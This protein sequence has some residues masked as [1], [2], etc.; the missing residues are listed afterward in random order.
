[1]LLITEEPRHKDLQK[2]LNKADINRSVSVRD[3]KQ[4]SDRPVSFH[5]LYDCFKDAHSGDDSIQHILYVPA[6]TLPGTSWVQHLKADVVVTGAMAQWSKLDDGFFHETLLNDSVEISSSSV[7]RPGCILLPATLFSEENTK[8]VHQSAN[9]HVYELWLQLTAFIKKCGF[10]TIFES[11]MNAVKPLPNP[12]KVCGRIGFAFPILAHHKLYSDQSPS[13]LDE[14]F[15][16]A[17][18]EELYQEFKQAQE[19]NRRC[20]LE[21][22]QAKQKGPHN[23]PDELKSPLRQLN[24][25][26]QNEPS[27]EKISVC[28]TSFPA[29]FESLQK[30]LEQIT[31]H[32]DAIYLHLNNADSIPDFI[33]DNQK[34]TA[35]FGEDFNAT[36]KTRHLGEIDQGYIFILDDDNNIPEDYFQKSV[37]AL[38]KYGNKAAITYHG[39]ILR[40]DSSW[41]YDK[42]TLYGYTKP[43]EEDALVTLPGS[44]FL[45]YHSSLISLTFKDFMPYTMVDLLFAIRF[46]ESNIP[47]ICIARKS[48][49][50]SQIEV[51]D[52][53]LWQQF[54]SKQTIHSVVSSTKN[55]CFEEYGNTLNT[56]NVK[57]ENYRENYAS[58]YEDQKKPLGWDNLTG[59]VSV[60]TSRQ[61]LE[62][63]YVLM[64]QSYENRIMKGK[65]LSS[66]HTDIKNKYDLLN[67]NYHKIQTS[68]EIQIGEEVGNIIYKKSVKQFCLSVKNILSAISK[69]Q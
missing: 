2:S 56:L 66:D 22:E 52:E 61:K 68:L 40:P 44:G 64:S 63:F 29:R 36:G 25:L 1:V 67:T 35:T 49:W 50:L 12:Y 14:G 34:I 32:V 45:A 43:L 28:I 47:I 38:K 62:Y 8:H 20:E 33:S 15:L 7:I 27:R 19:A 42:Y 51:E 24:A 26:T 10:E 31:P 55:W 5:E 57:S 6:K 11:D 37:S 48:D 9:Q 39:S 65:K 4:N 54:N 3:G 16:K 69:Q 58:I 59:N 21:V 41:Y 46:H 18:H 13:K 30:V 53:G 17:Y 23:K 60:I